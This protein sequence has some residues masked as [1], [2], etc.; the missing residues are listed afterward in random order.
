ML[1]FEDISLIIIADA[2]ENPK[3]HWQSLWER[4]YPLSTHIT[5]SEH[6]NTEEWT[7]LINQAIKDT[8]T[9][10]IIA[11]HS[12]GV[13]AFAKWLYHTSLVEQKLIYGALLVA[14]T[15]IN[16]STLP[17]EIKTQISQA[18]VNFPTALICSDNDPL[19][20]TQEAQMLSESLG[21]K[22]YCLEKAGHINAESGFG[23]WQWGMR[24][25]QDI[26][27]KHR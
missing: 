5:C 8:G 7:K 23:P 15:S 13:L 18:R 17:P 27:M 26:I 21:A 24:L 9:P 11:A 4:G 22:L 6:Q 25:M 12:I 2:K 1:D 19:C 14:P 3:G 20:T 16:Q 10:V